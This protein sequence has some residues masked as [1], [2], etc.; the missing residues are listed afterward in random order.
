MNIK[1]GLK[2]FGEA[3]VEAV[4]KEMQQLH[5]RKVMIA[6]DPSE[7][8]PGLKREALAYLMF[9]KRKRGGKI[10]GCGC[11]DGH[12][13]RVYTAKEDASSPTV[14]TEAVFLMAVIDAMEQREVAMFNVPGAF[15]QADMD[16]LVHVRFTG[17]MVDLLL[18]IDRDMY[19]PCVTLEKMR[20]SCMLSC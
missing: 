9:L 2:M 6:W 19:E 18:E 12:K 3:G 10:K 7:L 8:T 15:M 13:Q 11:T 20:G 4:K 17:K 16:E 5:D 1:Q 14:A